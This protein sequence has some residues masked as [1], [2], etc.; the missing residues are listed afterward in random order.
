[1]LLQWT[2]IFLVVALIAGALGFTGLSAGTAWIARVFFFIFLVLFI[3]SFFF[4]NKTNNLPSGPQ[5]RV[6]RDTDERE[7]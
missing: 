1:M 5:I 4:G 7:R 2:I 3:A 6:E